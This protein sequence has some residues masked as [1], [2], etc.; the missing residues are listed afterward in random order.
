MIA[1]TPRAR[2]QAVLAGPDAPTWLLASDDLRTWGVSSAAAF[3]VVTH[4]YRPAGTVDGYT[5]YHLQR[6]GH[7]HGAPS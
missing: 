2:L 4:R 6:T 7:R 5:V 3:S 1:A